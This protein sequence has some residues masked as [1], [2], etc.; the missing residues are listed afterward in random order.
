[1][2]QPRPDPTPSRTLHGEEILR[3]PLVREL[4]EAR[5]IA[6]LSTLEP[7]GSI[8]AVPLWYAD[9]G[10]TIVFATGSKSRKVRNVR[11]DPRATVTLHDSRPGMEICG[12]SIRGTVEIVENDAAAPLI[13]QVHR[14]YLTE[15]GRQAPRGGRVPRLRRRRAPLPPGVRGDVGRA[16]ERSRRSR[17]PHGRWAR[18]RPDDSAALSLTHFRCLIHRTRRRHSERPS[19]LLA[20]QARKLDAQLASWSVIGEPTA[21]YWWSR[22]DSRAPAETEQA[23]IQQDQ[24]AMLADHAAVIDRVEREVEGA[25]AAA[26]A[27]REAFEQS[28]IT[29]M[30]AGDTSPY[31]GGGRFE[32]DSAR[33][34]LAAARA[35]DDVR[36]T[37]RGR[38]LMTLTK[39]RERAQRADA[40]AEEARAAVTELDERRRQ[41]VEERAAIVAAAHAEAARIV[42]EA[43]V[44]EER[45]SE[46]E[47]HADEIYASREAEIERLAAEAAQERRAEVEEEVREMVVA[48]QARADE[49]TAN[50]RRADEEAHRLVAEAQREAGRITATAIATQERA[51]A[52]AREAEE[53]LAAAKAESDRLMAVTAQERL[54]QAEAHAK[55]ILEE[56]RTESDR[57]MFA[58]AE[59]EDRAAKLERVAKELHENSLSEAASF[60]AERRSQVEADAQERLA[61]ARAE[62]EEIL[63]SA[64]AE[65]GRMRSAAGQER[66]KMRDLLSSALASL[67]TPPSDDASGGIV[68]DLSTKLRDPA[69]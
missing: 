5:L 47:R 45:A 53:S 19:Q 2:P 56:A 49:I 32:E 27:K 37:S 20:D 59:A 26:A 8:H 44:T 54:E 38:A 58:A 15:D 48:A 40:A 9:G 18:A 21:T 1:M 3:D 60:E 12:A 10:D 16:R 11:R 6:V 28:Q 52:M 29:R 24:A 51:V 34:L 42:A 57:L 55:E 7:D 39:A 36:Q 66:D 30:R 46:R 63:A 35:A 67:E 4:V 33:L 50:A 61:S 41:A 23:D 25:L 14:R 31:G 22:G 43:R 13:E 68:H 62:A 17:P 64:R 65:A 69:N